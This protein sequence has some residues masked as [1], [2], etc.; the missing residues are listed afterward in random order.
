[1]RTVLLAL[2][3]VF[4]T[5][6]APSAS[7]ALGALAVQGRGPKTGYTR[8]SFGPRWTDVDRKRSSNGNVRGS[9]MPKKNPEVQR[10]IDDKTLTGKAK[11]DAMRLALTGRGADGKE[12]KYDDI[13]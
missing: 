8:E 6:A 12:A 2:L 13:P 7:D 5:G 3:V 11:F 9:L 4:G 10:I 1:M